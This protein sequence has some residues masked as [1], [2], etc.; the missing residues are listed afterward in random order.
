MNQTT[1]AVIMGSDSDLPTMQAAIDM[2]ARFEVPTVTRILS[3]PH[4]R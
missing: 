4:S 1:V 2:L 3:A